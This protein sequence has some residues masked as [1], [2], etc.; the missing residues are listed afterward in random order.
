MTLASATPVTV[1]AHD[2]LPSSTSIAVTAKLNVTTDTAEGKV[3]LTA[4]LRRL[5]AESGVTEGTLHIYCGHTTCGFVI[6]DE[7]DTGLDTD[8]REALDRIIPH[9]NNHYYTHDKL[10]TPEERL[11]H[12]ERDNGHSHIRTMIATQPELN[13]PI[14]AGQLYLGQWQAIMLVEFDGPRSRE[15]LARIHG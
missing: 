14:T 6:N 2:V 12:G 9:A 5:V 1:I 8:T 7:D 11:L 3:N 4:E 10:R 13:I 15:L